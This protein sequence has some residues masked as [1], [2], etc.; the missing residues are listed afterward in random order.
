MIKLFINKNSFEKDV[1]DLKEL[2][3]FKNKYFGKDLP[4][5]VVFCNKALSLATVVLLVIPFLM[6]YLGFS[7]Y[8]LLTLV[9]CVVFNVVTFFMMNQTKLY[10]LAMLI[11]SYN[12][13]IIVLPLVF[14]FGNG[15]DT[16]IYLYFITGLV[17]TA[18]FIDGYKMAIS[19]VIQSVWYGLIF[20]F[21]YLHQDRLDQFV[22]NTNISPSLSIIINIFLISLT[23]G[24]L[25]RMLSVEYEDERK[26]VLKLVNKLEDLSIKDPLSG[27]FNRRFLFSYLDEAIERYK[28]DGNPITLIIFDIDKFK[29]LNDTYGH[30]VGDEV[31]VNV[32]KVLQHS[33]RSY[34]IVSRYGGEEFI[35]VL[36]GASEETAYFRA[37]QMR[38]KVE[39]SI[40]SASISERKVTI[41]GGI[42]LYSNKM[43][44]ESFIDAADKNLYIAKN[45]GR[46]KIVWKD[47]QLQ[48]PEQ[49]NME[50]NYLNNSNND[51]N[52]LHRRRS[53]K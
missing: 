52:S 16:G 9:Y 40:L 17:I 44:V 6:I 22:S 28:K 1:S 24:P 2:D 39:D 50:F 27:A 21:S 47:G 31:I 8:L 12:I 53:D 33:C 3:D 25:I 37:D 13:N 43:T 19:L 26:V 35:V 5:R 10:N 36:P 15:A 48:S 42:A 20:Y 11:V 38:Q 46:N 29:E 34:D 45:S 51:L 41:S 23:L 14:I 30:L 4:L 49:K 18:L 7:T 32:V